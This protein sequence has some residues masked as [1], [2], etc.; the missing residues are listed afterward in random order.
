MKTA[1]GKYAKFSK[2]GYARVLLEVER[3]S[4]QPS[5]HVEL[6]DHEWNDQLRGG[7][8]ADWIAAARYGAEFGLRIADVT[9]ARVTV[10]RI[11]ALLVDAT[12]TTIAAAAA[13]AVWRATEFTPAHSLRERIEA[14]ACAGAKEPWKLLRF[15]ADEPG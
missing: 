2:G 13:D 4:P 15:D 3:P 8:F 7:R 14:T 5:V 11:V 12:S 1:E 10:R 6:D 9:D